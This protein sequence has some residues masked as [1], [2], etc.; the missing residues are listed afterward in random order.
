M[1]ASGV[2]LA[3]ALERSGKLLTRLRARSKNLEVKIRRHID[4]RLSEMRLNLQQ[5]LNQLRNQSA[6][7]NLAEAKTRQ[8]VDVLAIDAL[9]DLRSYLDELLVRTE[10]AARYPLG[11]KSRAGSRDR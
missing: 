8:L 5:G 3:L 7:L 11:R 1:V 9:A 4:A 2:S 6:A 10:V